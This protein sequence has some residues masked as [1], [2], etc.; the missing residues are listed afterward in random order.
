MQR[1]AAVIVKV[2]FHDVD[3]VGVVWHGHYAKYLELA[4]CELLESFG[5]NYDAMA[6]SGYAWPVIDISLRFVAAARFGQRLRVQATL[7][8]WEHRLGIDYH[9]SDA[10]TGERVCKAHTNQVAVKLAN[11]EMCLAS[12]PILFER[13][14]LPPP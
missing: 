12:P 4:R 1:S 11:W 7:V 2:P 8:E 5:Y 6:A 14:G 9:V 10:D 3:A 13:L